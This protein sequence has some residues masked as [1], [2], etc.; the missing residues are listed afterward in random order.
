MTIK[1]SR[2]LTKVTIAFLESITRKKM[3]IGN[4]LWSIRE[5]DEISQADFSKLLGISRQYL[6][7]VERGRRAV[8]VEAAANFANK[9]GHS[10]KQFIRL[11]L[12]DELDRCGIHYDI[13]LHDQHAA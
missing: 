10:P 12:Q 13:E 9:L 4:L 2:K 11:A 3:T 7:D 8:S 1:K 6:C 5:C